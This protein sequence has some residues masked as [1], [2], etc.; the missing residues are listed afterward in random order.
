VVPD[1]RV[2]NDE[3]EEEHKAPRAK[4]SVGALPEDSVIPPKVRHAEQDEIAA[5]PD[6]ERA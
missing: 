4:S 2:D 5:Q 3:R 1:R 6:S